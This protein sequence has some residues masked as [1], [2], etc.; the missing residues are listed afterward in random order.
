MSTDG[1]VTIKWPDDERKYRLGI[2]ELRELQDRCDAGPA[3][4]FKRI[5]ESSW[6]FDDIRETIRLGLIGGGLDP[7]RALGIVGRYV[8]PGQLVKAATIAQAILLAAL[9]SPEDDT[10][11]K[12][13]AETE[14]P[15]TNGSLSPNTTDQAL[16]SAGPHER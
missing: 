1:S 2:G 6:R 14:H 11:K 13:D 16:S 12:S 7:Q 15:K 10:E 4:I 9:V 3:Q 8:V 5:A